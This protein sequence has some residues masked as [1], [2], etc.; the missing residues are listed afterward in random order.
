MQNILKKYLLIFVTFYLTIQ[1]KA[2]DQLTMKIDAYLNAHVNIKGFSGSVLIAKKDNIIYK[3][4]FG[5]ANAE[6]K[7]N[8]TPETKFLLASV[9][10]QFTSMAIMLL[11]N[12]G[13]VKL[14]G[15]ISDYLPYYR[16]DIGEKI[17][18]HQL[19]IHTSGIP[20]YTELPNFFVDDSRDP[21]NAKDFILK[22]CSN[23]LEFQPD[24]DQK[25]NNSAYCIL[26]GI[27]EEISGLTYGEF[28]KKNIFEKL[29][30]FNS[31]YESHKT[32]IENE[33]E[34]YSKEGD[35]LVHA[36][37]LDISVAYAAGGLYSTVEDMY[38]WDRSLYTDFLLPKKW[39]DTMFVNYKNGFGY[40]WMNSKFFGHQV[41]HHSGGIHG[42]STHIARLID[43]D[44][45]II[46]LGNTDFN[47]ASLIN[48]DLAAILFGEK[49]EIPGVKKSISVDEKTLKKYT[50][51]YELEKGFTILITVEGGNLVLQATGQP[52]FSMLAE[53][54]KDFFLIN[55]PI[56]ITFET[57]KKGKATGMILHQNGHHTL[58]KIH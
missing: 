40:G 22:F 32:I 45:C 16:K 17:T 2:Q 52:K 42:F 50:G 25:Y 48:M 9:T 14:E 57:D 10:K 49:Y 54:E 58:K 21:Y 38:L 51:E 31:G 24:A 26:G 13:K 5:Y 11:V 39:R 7:V 4:G 3:K 33:A 47:G 34:G 18:I 37:Y 35:K 28:I 46:T 8:N 41:I 43:D 36:D 1:V 19:L 27:I 23:D 44:I 15:K 55:Y 29:G 53:T 20:G 6:H 12:D 56:S 30:M